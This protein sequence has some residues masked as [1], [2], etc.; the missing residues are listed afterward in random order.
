MKP[1]TV[2]AKRDLL[3]AEKFDSDEVLE[4]ANDFFEQELYGD[5]LEFYRKLGDNKGV[6]RVMHKAVETGD[7]EILW[8]I[9]RYNK[10]LITLSHWE[11]CGD[12][13]MRNQKYRDAAFAFKRAGK[14]EKRARAEREFLPPPEEDKAEETVTAAGDDQPGQ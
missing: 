12:Q 13:A 2:L 10:A 8:R 1:L 3:A 5:A 7:A 4:Y 9:A 11:Q 14:D 6:E